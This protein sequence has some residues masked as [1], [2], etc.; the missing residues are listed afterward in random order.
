MRKPPPKI[1]P[2]RREDLAAVEAIEAA[3]FDSDR[4]SRRSLRYYL[5]SETAVFLVLAADGQVAGY[6]L[7]SFRQGSQRARLFSIALAPCEHGRGLGRLLL[8][9]SERAAKARGAIAMRLEVRIDNA[10]A[11]ALYEKNG[12]RRF[13]MVEN[14]YEDGA[15][16][17]RFEKA[18]A[19]KKDAAPARQPSGASLSLARSKPSMS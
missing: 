17:L 14:F 1:R 3:V 8:G 18:F 11:I 19:Q 12:Y 7:V 2:A 9:A 13:A 4:L 10:R 15:A 6:S 5:N 16:A